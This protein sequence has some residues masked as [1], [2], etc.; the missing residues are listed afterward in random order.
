MVSTS[1]RDP[2][3]R[4]C[5]FFQFSPTSECIGSYRAEVTPSGAAAQFLD[6]AIYV[7][8]FAC[9]VRAIM[10]FMR[11]YTYWMRSVRDASPCSQLCRADYWCRV[12]VR[13]CGRYTCETAALNK[14]SDCVICHVQVEKRNDWSAHKQYTGGGRRHYVFSSQTYDE[15]SERSWFDKRVRWTCAGIQWGGGGGGGGV[16]LHVNVNSEYCEESTRKARSLTVR[17]MSN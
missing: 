14:L 7:T 1:Q 8:Y 6:R 10:Q 9:G 13:D 11:A 2:E 12:S 4:N 16:Q 15:R 5:T 17:G 3:L